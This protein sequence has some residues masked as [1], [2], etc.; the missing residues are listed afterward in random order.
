MNNNIEY[1]TQI[2]T[3]C[4]QLRLNLNPIIILNAVEN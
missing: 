2:W 3:W 1:G 4:P